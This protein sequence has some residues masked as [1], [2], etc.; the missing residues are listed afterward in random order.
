MTKGFVG[1]TLYNR[2][3]SLYINFEDNKKSVNVEIGCIDC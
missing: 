1:K 2:S 3:K